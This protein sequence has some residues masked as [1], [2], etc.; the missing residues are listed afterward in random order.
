GALVLD[1]HAH[2]AR[3]PGRKR[4]D[5]PAAVCAAAAMSRRTF[6]PRQALALGPEGTDPPGASK[7]DVWICY[8]A[9]RSSTL[10]CH[11]THTPGSVHAS[12]AAARTRRRA[13]ACLVPGPP[14]RAGFTGGAQ[15]PA[16]AALAHRRRPPPH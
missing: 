3:P 15:R 8:D 1:R 7:G 5:D 12:R 6:L 9:R 16:A 13:A 10:R 2:P 4:L 11:E 14:G